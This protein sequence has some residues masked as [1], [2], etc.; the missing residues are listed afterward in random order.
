M[1]I[2]QNN[3]IPIA[4]HCPYETHRIVLL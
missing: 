4:D 3:V 2:A 1:I